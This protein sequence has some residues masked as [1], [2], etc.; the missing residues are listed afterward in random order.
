MKAAWCAYARSSRCAEKKLDT[1][2][3][4]KGG[5]AANKKPA[6][7]KVGQ[8]C[9]LQVGPV[10][11]EEQHKASLNTGL[12][13]ALCFQW[14]FLVGSS[15]S[16][17]APVGS[18]SRSLCAAS[19]LP[20]AMQAVRK[21]AEPKKATAVKKEAPEKG[22]EAKQTRVKKEYDLPGQTR[23]TPPEVH[24]RFSFA[25]YPWQAAAGVMLPLDSSWEVYLT[26]NKYRLCPRLLICSSTQ[27]R[28]F[29]FRYCAPWGPC[30]AAL[31]DAPW[32]PLL[33]APLVPCCMLQNDSLRKFYTSLLEQRPES[34]MAM[35]WCAC[36]SSMAQRGTAQRIACLLGAASAK[37]IAKAVLAQH[38][39]VGPAADCLEV[40]AGL[41]VQVRA[42]R[43]VATGT[44]PGVGGQPAEAR[45]RGQVSL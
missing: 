34:E 2:A 12:T 32:L 43:P 11:C 1:S 45:Y 23:D 18:P 27:P 15:P 9:C 29:G 8:G 44:G 36:L 37:T 28:G 30:T 41:A 24:S 16:T 5:D 4:K 38:V 13:W 22:E 21:E 42:A 6:V 35:K 33:Q 31:A 40:V 14:Y 10:P 17:V 26:C 3:A 7:K 25:G 39:A 20:P 19:G